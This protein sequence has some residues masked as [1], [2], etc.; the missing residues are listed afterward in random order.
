MK[1]SVLTLLASVGLLSAGFFL[2]EDLGAGHN[3]DSVIEDRVNANL[4]RVRVKGQW[5]EFPLMPMAPNVCQK[6]GSLFHK[7]CVDK[8]L[9]PESQE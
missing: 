7:D 6:D 4:I 8:V 3:R 9:A 1:R 5:Q 2:L